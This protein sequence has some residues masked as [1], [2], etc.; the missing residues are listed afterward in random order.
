MK[1]TREAG[2]AWKLKREVGMLYPL[3]KRRFG[4]EERQATSLPANLS[5][6]NCTTKTLQPLDLCKEERGIINLPK[7]EPLEPVMLVVWISTHRVL[8][9]AI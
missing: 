3:E 8:P 1:G 2:S 5:P 7:K 6:G 4:Q 9:G